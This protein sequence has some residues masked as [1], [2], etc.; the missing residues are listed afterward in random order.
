[1][2]VSA[3][4]P[5]VRLEHVSVRFG[6]QP[7]LRDITLEIRHG[8]TLAV[9]GESGCGKTVLLKL[10]VGLLKPDR[11]RVLFDNR[12]IAALSTVDLASVRRRF[13]F[14]FQGAA[15]FDSLSVYENVAYPLR[16][17]RAWRG[18]DPRTR[19]KPRL[20]EVGLAESAAA[21]LPAELSGGMRQARRPGTRA[22]HSIRT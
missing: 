12:D 17:A 15:L 18:G 8:E 3:E 5:I 6:N 19:A 14:L 1:M 16:A 2:N 20:K 11:G 4:S 7:V 13:G 21:K 9:I 22:W 10:L